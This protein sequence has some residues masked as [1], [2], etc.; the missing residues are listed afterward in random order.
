MKNAKTVWVIDDDVSIAWVLEK[1]LVREGYEV[2][3]FRGVKPL[4]LALKDARPRVVISDIKMP[5]VDGLKLLELLHDNFPAIPVIIMTAYS[6]FETTI[7]SYK[8]GAFEYL[9]KPFDIHQA[10]ALVDQAMLQAHET[11]LEHGIGAGIQAQQNENI[12]TGLKRRHAPGDW[13]REFEHRV[14]SLL[15]S[16]QSDVSRHLYREIDRI[17]IQSA[18]GFTHGHKQKAAIVLGWGRN[19]LTR[20]M[21]D[22][23]M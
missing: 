19:T 7:T 5:G 20:K 6:D 2:S 18:L 22:L 4:L 10:L 9:A 11:M 8:K 12:K 16:G 3:V 21:Q 1:A 17:L 23:G 13:Q 15:D 14:N